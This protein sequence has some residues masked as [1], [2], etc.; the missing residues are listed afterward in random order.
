MWQTGQGYVGRPGFC[1]ISP[2]KRIRA[3]RSG[4]VSHS[5]L[6]KMLVLCGRPP[7]QAAGRS[8]VPRDVSR[9]G[10]GALL[11]T[12][13]PSVV[14]VSA[15]RA[16]SA[17]RPSM[18][19]HLAH[20]HGFKLSPCLGVFSHRLLSSRRVGFTPL[21]EGNVLDS[22]SAAFNHALVCFLTGC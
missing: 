9:D 6:Q 4:E 7:R 15:R 12:S 16:T 20:L 21:R 17:S 11:P 1:S 13:T 10:G 8:S 22:H 19:G 14:A 2:T 5:H 3:W 18:S